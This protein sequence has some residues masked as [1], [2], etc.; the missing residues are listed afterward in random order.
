MKQSQ[1]MV[2][3]R[4]FREAQFFHIR[5]NASLSTRYDFSKNK[6]AFSL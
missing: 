2:L 5:L 4:M 1:K 3:Q 6:V